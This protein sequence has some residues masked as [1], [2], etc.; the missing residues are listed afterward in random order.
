MPLFAAV[1]AVFTPPDYHYLTSLSPLL[2]RYVS[3]T[4]KSPQITWIWSV[5]RRMTH[6]EQAKFVAF[7]T[8]SSKVPLEGFQALKGET[9]VVQKLTIH[10]A[11]GGDGGE[12]PLP[13]AHT[14][15]NQLDLPEYGDEETLRRKLLLAINETEGFGLA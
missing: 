10:K 14:C 15:F 8:G 3:Y 5:L 9:G 2:G 1:F 6:D 4:R 11:Y 13:V 7:V 12:M